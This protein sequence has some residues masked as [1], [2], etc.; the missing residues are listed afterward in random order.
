[1]VDEN[2][3]EEGESEGEPQSLVD[4]HKAALKKKSNREMKEEER[5]KVEEEK[6]SKEGKLREV[7]KKVH[8]NIMILHVVG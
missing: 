8:N 3:E 4:Q 2:S 5:K 6:A 1:M 7:R